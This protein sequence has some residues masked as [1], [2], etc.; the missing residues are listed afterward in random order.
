[1]VQGK[2]TC[3]SD[4][5]ALFETFADI[6]GKKKYFIYDVQTDEITELTKAEYHMYR[7]EGDWIN[8][9]PDEAY[10]K[11]MIN[12][13]KNAAGKRIQIKEYANETNS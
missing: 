1:M 7:K 9:V 6:D 13:A 11:Y 10:M 4:N 12:V 3:L 8:L 2:L 5:L